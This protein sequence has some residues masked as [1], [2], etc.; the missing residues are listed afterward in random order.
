MKTTLPLN[1]P[2]FY[3]SV[4]D[5]LTTLCLDTKVTPEN[6]LPN[7]ADPES[8]GYDVR[9]AQPGGIIIK[10]GSYLKIPLGFRMYAPAGWWLS[11]APRSST[12]IK[13]HI[14]AL[15]GVID[16]TYEN[17]M[18]FVG[19]YIPDSSDLLNSNVDLS[20]EFGERIAQII[21]VERQ[22]M[23]IN[24]I[25]SKEIDEKYSLRN[26]SRGIGGFGASGKF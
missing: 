4:R 19:Q 7:K 1:T 22:D 17:E 16:Q 12:F 24:S 6:F 26:T 9:C 5:D 14:H 21:P 18:M 3:F 8:T 15:Y 23:V 2:Q 25:S 20:I 13:K 10:P 11:L